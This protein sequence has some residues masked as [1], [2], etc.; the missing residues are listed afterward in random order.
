MT[1]TVLT[2]GACSFGGRTPPST[3]HVLSATPAESINDGGP[4]SVLLGP[5]SLPDVVLRPQ[6][7]TR[8][9][10]GRVVFAEYH[11]WAGDL[12]ANV[13]QVLVENLSDRLGGDTV[14][15]TG[16]GDIDTDYRVAI[17]FLRF[18][19]TPGR[20]AVLE[21][22]WRI[23]ACTPACLVDVHRFVI[24]VPV[25]GRDYDALVSGLDEGL[26]VLS[27]RIAQKLAG[28]PTCRRD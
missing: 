5:L 3:F 22:I 8:P 18:D 11:R 7:V 24:E 17:R 13:E 21:G 26:A 4:L 9:E 1:L 10:P 27:D 28:R 15:P 19:G 23:K 14:I 6:I 12:R 2:L 25:A 20:Q 16:G